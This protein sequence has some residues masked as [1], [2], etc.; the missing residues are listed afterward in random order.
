MT[1]ATALVL[2]AALAGAAA[3]CS[4][5][6]H[7]LIGTA[8]PPVAPESVRVYYKPPPKYEEIASVNASSQGSLALTSQQ[9]MDKAIQRLKAEA[10][11]L[12]ANGILLQTVYDTQSGSIGAGGGG[13]SYGPNSA[14]GVGV[15]G[16]FALTSKVVQGLAIYVPPQ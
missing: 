5:S 3:A 1:R 11:R 2:A 9:N 16:S 14:T 10:A 13:A 6:S 12:G 7:V 15:G 4:T 8:R